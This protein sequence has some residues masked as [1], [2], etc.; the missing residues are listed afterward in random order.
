MGK[1]ILDESSSQGDD[2]GENG[3]DEP[4]QRERGYGSFQI[5]RLLDMFRFYS[6]YI[7][8]YHEIRSLLELIAAQC[9]K[10]SRSLLGVEMA[11]SLK[12][13]LDA[14]EIE[15]K[16]GDFV[17]PLERFSSHKLFEIVKA[18]QEFSLESVK[19]ELVELINAADLEAEK[20]VFWVLAPD[21]TS[22]RFNLKHPFGEKVTNNF[23]S[24][25]HDVREARKCYALARYTA[26]VFHCMRVLEKGLHTL[27][28][29][30]NNKHNAGIVFNKTV[31]ETNWGNIIGE[32]QIA[33]ENPKRLKKLTPIPAKQQMAFYSRLALEFE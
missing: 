26:S 6:S 24:T 9:E 25:Q 15:C 2:S 1:N 8:T 14:F 28:H 19:H 18:P 20:R 12:A 16:R 21:M 23:P 5:L 4:P 13:A 7:R 10:S 32:I 33:L 31:E 11:A 17:R 22:R 30:L 27:V 29:D 3:G